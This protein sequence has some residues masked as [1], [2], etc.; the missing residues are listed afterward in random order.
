MKQKCDFSFFFFFLFSSFVFSADPVPEIIVVEAKI[1]P[2]DEFCDLE[3][4]IYLDPIKEA[5]ELGELRLAIM[6]QDSG[7]VSAVLDKEGVDF[8]ELDIWRRTPFEV[9]L[10]TKK[11]DL[12]QAFLLKGK[13]LQRYF[14]RKLL[15]L[16][17]L[18]KILPEKGLKACN[19]DEYPYGED[20]GVSYSE[21]IGGYECQVYNR[22]PISLGSSGILWK[23]GVEVLGTG[24]PEMHFA[25]KTFFSLLPDGNFFY[26]LEEPASLVELKAQS[27]KMYE[28]Q[29]M[30]SPE[31]ADEFYDFWL[32]YADG[33]DKERALALKF[34][35]ASV[36]TYGGVPYNDL[37]N[38]ILMDL[39]HHEL[40]AYHEYKLKT[41]FLGLKF[42]H[43]QNC[44]HL[45]IKT[46]NLVLDYFIPNTIRLID[47][48]AS[49]SLN[50]DEDT[51]KWITS[52]G[53]YQSP[54]RGG[55]S[56][57]KQDIFSAGLVALF[58][59]YP[60]QKSYYQSE[61]K[62]KRPGRQNK[63]ELVEEMIEFLEGN[64]DKIDTLI[65]RMLAPPESRI[66][67]AEKLWKEYAAL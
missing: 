47:F 46:T 56:P 39:A 22:G 38:F 7:W 18:E 65:V 3:G 48:G 49:K 51:T 50:T 52:T 9:A 34:S 17:D 62:E 21:T 63:I 55:H 25:L 23:I 26:S 36:H 45:D 33:V 41:F 14:G 20:T 35:S 43:K 19:R 59:K 13:G 11:E 54:W 58:L 28:D 12:I 53:R 44:V 57:K 32:S 10:T 16:I 5:F 29:V 4:V 24:A 1:V 66:S 61:H 40:G 2:D 8:Y 31:G 6:M 30:S 67:C 15:P 64:D 37:Q 27:K 60:F 42:L